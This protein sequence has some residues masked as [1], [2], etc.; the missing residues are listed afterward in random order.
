MEKTNKIAAG[1]ILICTGILL[2]LA[3]IKQALL[4][5]GIFIAISGIGIIVETLEKNEH[6]N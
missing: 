5:L 1:L 6:E 4:L 3:E 2:G